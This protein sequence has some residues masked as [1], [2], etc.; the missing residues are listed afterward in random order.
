[1]ESPQDKQWAQKYLLGPLNEPEPSEETGPGAHFTSSVPRSRSSS[2]TS[3]SPATA[4]TSKGPFVSAYLTPPQSASPTRSSFHPSNPYGPSRKVSGEHSDN[5]NGKGRRRNSSL[6]QRFP[7]DMSHRPL[8]QLRKEEKAARRSP[9]LRKKHQPGADS[10]D[11]LDRTMFGL[12][13]HEGPYDATLM[14]RNRSSKIS[15]V[16]AVRETNA[17]A[18]KATPQEYIKDSLTKHVPLQ[19][20]S[21]I[22]PGMVSWDGKKM[23]YEEGADLMREP[24]AAGGAYK[25]WDH[26]KYLPEDL[27]GKG[28]P[29]YSIE[30]ALKEQ[31]A[32][33][34]RNGMSD[35]PQSFEMQPPKHRPANGGRQRSVSGDHEDFR[36]GAG[37]HPGSFLRVPDSNDMNRSNSTG[38]RIGEGLKKRFGNLRTNKHQSEA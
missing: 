4:S 13:H 2:S 32:R 6:G 35:E 19:G 14:A 28:E 11:K 8:D 25:R 5:A 16:E 23:V 34:A 26:V 15:P 17:E 18:I 20:T 24:D 38:R 9:H 29:S 21:L 22:P 12:Y 1:M 37:R 33:K 30:K 31:K 10:I 7:G 27:K 3:K 36:R